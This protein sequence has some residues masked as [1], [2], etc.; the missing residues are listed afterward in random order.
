MIDHDI[1]DDDTPLEPRL[2]ELARAPREA[3]WARIEAA[4]R[5]ERGAVAASVPATTPATV[6]T[7]RDSVVVSIDA[8]RS[9]RR[10]ARPWAFV[11]AGLAAGL[12]FGVAVERFRRGDVV[13]GNGGPSIA[14]TTPVAPNAAAPE[15]GAV[16]ATMPDESIAP[17]SPSATVARRDSGATPRPV[18][19]RTPRVVAPEAPRFAQREPSPRTSAPAGTRDA[20]RALYQAA[21]VQTL[22]QAEAVLVAYRAGTL[23]TAQA[24]QLGRWARDVLSSTRLLIDSPAARDP[25]LQR[26]LGDLELLLAQLVQL[27]GS[28]LTPDE[29][30]LIDQGLRARDLLPRIRSAVPAGTAASTE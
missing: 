1:H 12:L 29:R 19:P 17:A 8:A 3:M 11:A 13:E 26:L 14:V 22:T 27:S 7:T 21:A 25:E 4:R 6:G 23:D 5:A 18:A 16:Q 2:A 15:S 30:E 24:S 20:S 9:R 28:R 10:S